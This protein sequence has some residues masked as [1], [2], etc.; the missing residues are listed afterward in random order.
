MKANPNKEKMQSVK[1]LI[2]LFIFLTSSQ[3]LAVVRVAFYERVN[4]NG[5]PV[6]LIPGERFYHVAVEVDGFWY[7]A[8][9]GRR[10]MARP[11]PLNAGMVV[12]LMLTHEDIVVPRERVRKY[13]GWEFDTSYSWTK[14]GGTYCSRLVANILF[15]FI[16]II[17]TTMY[18][19]GSHWKPFS[20]APR[21][22]K[23]VGI[24]Q[25]LTSLQDAGF[26]IEYDMRRPHLNKKGERA[27][28][29]CSSIL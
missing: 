28:K 12:S 19:M 27:A 9:P 24:G 17:P 25:L 14:S 2:C 1:R 8:L 20:S 18:F 3:S 26:N 7:D 11:A 15:G 16:D 5:T 6:E 10:V 29:S 21:G 23:G 13:I 4:N 22:K